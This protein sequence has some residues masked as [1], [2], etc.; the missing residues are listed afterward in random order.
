MLGN[1]AVADFYAV[2][3]AIRVLYN[4]CEEILQGADRQVLQPLGNCTQF[5]IELDRPYVR[6]F[7]FMKFT[8]NSNRCRCG[9]NW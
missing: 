1:T 6:V 3:H 9:G 8:A 5:Q 7:D 4:V 2:S